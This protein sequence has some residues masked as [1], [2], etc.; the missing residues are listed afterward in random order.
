MD[1]KEERGMEREAALGGLPRLLERG[2]WREMKGGKGGREAVGWL[3]DDK[4]AA[5][6]AT[7][8]KQG[9]CH[10]CSPVAFPPFSGH[11]GHQ[12]KLPCLPSIFLH[13]PSLYLSLSSLSPLRRSMRSH[14]GLGSL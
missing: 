1:E 5:Y 7:G 10:S 12:A 4:N 13:I 6:E 2:E 8:S 14:R 11:G 9:D 3:P